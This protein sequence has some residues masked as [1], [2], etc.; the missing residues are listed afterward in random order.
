MALIEV[1]VTLSAVV[2]VFVVYSHLE[3][4]VGLS[5]LIVER[6]VDL[7]IDIHHPALR[8]TGGLIRAVLPRDIVIARLHGG[9]DRDQ[10]AA[11][12]Y[13]RGVPVVCIVEGDA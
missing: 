13:K 8:D 9:D 3:T 12:A 1:E 7:R 2:V 4:L 11:R 10:S 5:V 6:V